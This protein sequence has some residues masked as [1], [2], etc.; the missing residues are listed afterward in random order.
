[1]TNLEH[2]KHFK[3]PEKAIELE[4]KL[5][6]GEI[7][8]EVFEVEVKKLELWAEEEAIK[9]KSETG[10]DLEKIESSSHLPK[11][12]IANTEKEL[13]I[14]EN[15]NQVNTEADKITRFDR[16]KDKA[17]KFLKVAAGVVGLAALPNAVEGQAPKERAPKVYTNKAE[18]DKAKQAYEDSL[19]LYNFSNLQEGRLVQR[20]REKGLSTKPYMDNPYKGRG[21]I[22]NSER[23]YIEPNKFGNLP[24][25]YVQ[26]IGNATIAPIS[27]YAYE[28]IE[29]M[30][31]TNFRYKKPVQ[32][33]V[34]QPKIESKKTT[35][36]PKPNV[37]PK[38]N[39]PNW[40]LVNDKNSKGENAVKWQRKTT[41]PITNKET[42]KPK[43]KKGEKKDTT[44]NVVDSQSAKEQK[45]AVLFVEK[46]YKRPT[47]KIKFSEL[48]K[49]EKSWFLHQRSDGVYDRYYMP[50]LR[51]DAVEEK[52]IGRI[53][54]HGREVPYTSGMKEQLA[55]Y[56][57]KPTQVGNSS[58]YTVSRFEEKTKGW[59]GNK[60]LDKKG[61][62]LIDLDTL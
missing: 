46:K 30:E 15:L 12:E 22:V 32:K 49:E 53:N 27:S 24:G 8:P 42:I 52:P 61:G 59:Q 58:N 44:E 4:N 34:Y 35:L 17:S 2:L 11:E 13:Q 9:F 54:I 45:E 26:D 28:G 47:E 23:P 33:V 36:L 40:E 19:E 29:S 20:L 3:N 21:G 51:E 18:Y 31:S 6:D 14:E 37:D 16:I 55:S 10:T 41:K 62:V 56:G 57:I 50:F 7:T 1:M 5:I 25:Y 39:D 38:F 60:L 48:T 43:I